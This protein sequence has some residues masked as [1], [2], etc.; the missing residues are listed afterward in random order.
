M[1]LRL[2][3]QPIWNGRV[4]ERLY[5]FPTALVHAAV[6]DPFTHIHPGQRSAPARPP[7]AGDE[8]EAVPDVPSSRPISNLDQI[9]VQGFIIS[10]R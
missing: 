2:R 7:S 8:V 6:D 5:E 4:A 9:L 3:I 1:A 10:G